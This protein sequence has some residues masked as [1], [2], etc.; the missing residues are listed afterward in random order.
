MIDILNLDFFAFDRDMHI[1]APIRIYLEKRGIRLKMGNLYV[2]EFMILMHRP[3]LILV[4]NAHGDYITH[5]L[6]KFLYKIGYNIVNINSEG[7]FHDEYQKTYVWGW[8]NDFILYHDKML[9]WNDQ[10]KQI[11]L[12]YYP[13]L[14]DKLEVC[15]ATGFDRYYLFNYETHNIRKKYNLNT[16]KKVIGIASFG[17]FKTITNVEYH[18]NNNPDYP[19]SNYELFIED[20]PKIKTIYHDLIYNNP[21][22]LFILRVH[23]EFLNDNKSSEF[24]E[25]L[26]FSNVLVSSTIGFMPD[27]AEA[28]AVSDIWISYESTT[29][30]EAWLL[31]KLVLYI[32]PTRTDFMRE[33]H[34][35]GVLICKTLTELEQLITLFYQNRTNKEYDSLSAIRDRIVSRVVGFSDGKNHERAAK[36]ILEE[37]K[38]AQRPPFFKTIFQLIRKI[39]WVFVL[40]FY[41]HKTSWYFKLRPNLSKPT[42]ALTEDKAIYSKYKQIY[43]E[44]IN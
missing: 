20:Y 8:N 7:N 29:S 16:Y 38:V 41:I 9:L 6:L 42:W 19:R 39:N 27:V 36:V 30:M 5:L 15:G 26:E 43:K 33:D 21:D 37:L 13:Y 23:P 40:K 32:N 44:Y 4:A 2:A 24:A 25:C 11:T 31:N 35:K 10:S 1:M 14:S 34:H 28:I 22:I 12:K 17:S 3:K 18:F